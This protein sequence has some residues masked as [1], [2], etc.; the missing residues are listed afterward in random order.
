VG[1]IRI[2]QEGKLIQTIGEGE[3]HRAPADAYARQQEATKDH[4]LQAKQRNP[5]ML[6]DSRSP[7]ARASKYAPH[8][9]D[10]IAPPLGTTVPQSVNHPGRYQAE[11]TLR[12]GSNEICIEAFNKTNTVSSYRECMTIQAQ[13]PAKR[14]NLYGIVVGV[15][16]FTHRDLNDLRYAQNDALSIKQTLESQAKGLYANI[17]I[18]PLL[19]KEVTPQSISQALQAI[20]NKATVNDTVVFFI[21]THGSADKNKL[22]LY[23]YRAHRYRIDFQE[24]FAAIQSIP[25]LKQILIVDACQS[26]Q[27]S[28]ILSA[29]YDSRA[30]VLAKSA[31]IHLLMATTRGTSAFESQDAQ[32][33]HGVFTH[34]ILQ[35]L[36]T[37][38]T[39]TNHDK[40]I[41]IL[42]LSD[43]L[44]SQPNTNQ[45]QYPVIRNVGGDVGMVKVA[46]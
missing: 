31:G 16:H 33:K 27:A 24:L 21:S 39:D 13:I 44:R 46:N 25:A 11:A 8:I 20:K 3:I 35:A 34:Q 42:E 36:Q 12:S 2:Y 5:V 9:G 7:Q 17:E 14:P 45:M 26:G 4:E 22:F 38:A 1:L 19:G 37:K 41:S 18:T 29:V 23:P 15:N 6:A 28:D 40:S 32:V 10:L 30:S 43:T